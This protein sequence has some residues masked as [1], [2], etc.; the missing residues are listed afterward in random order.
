MTGD[1]VAHC[2]RVL[3]LPTGRLAPDRPRAGAAILS[4]AR[5][6]E[7]SAPLNIGRP[8]IAPEQNHVLGSGACE[9]EWRRRR[10]RRSPLRQLEGRMRSSKGGTRPGF[11]M[12]MVILGL[13]ITPRVLSVGQC[14]VLQRRRSNLPAPDRR[15]GSIGTRAVGAQPETILVAWCC[16]P[17]AL[18]AARIASGAPHGAA[19]AFCS[20]AVL[21]LVSILSR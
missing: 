2:H 14:I 6:G 4:R 1:A 18:V 7:S 19:G 8:Q 13:T 17:A 15:H 16:H 12:R 10:A 3:P 20:L 21:G 5:C 9:A 11:V